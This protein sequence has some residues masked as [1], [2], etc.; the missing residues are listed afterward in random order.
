MY[1]DNSW[2]GHRQILAEYAGVPLSRPVF[3]SIYHGWAAVHGQHEGFRRI[4]GAP[5]FVWNQRDMD[6]AARRQVPNTR[7]IG[8]PFT[9]LAAMRFPQSPAMGKGTIAFPSH[10]AEGVNSTFDVLTFVD[11]VESATPG[12]Y[13]VSIYYRDLDRPETQVYRDAGWKV[14]SFGARTDP[15]FLRRFID[16]VVR[17]EHVVSNMVQTAIWYG[18]YL[19]RRV[20]ILGP[21][22]SNAEG[23]GVGA[24]S[25]QTWPSL[26]SQSLDHDASVAQSAFELGAERMVSPSQLRSE[27]GWDSVVAQAR[28]RAFSAIIGPRSRRFIAERERKRAAGLDVGP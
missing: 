20:Q 16:H 24:H 2:Y 9:Y 21:P 7:C 17:R 28:A 26:F 8:A 27:L 18:A 6:D 10:S 11:A 25:T 23:Q 4:T 22:A 13:T 14:I 5:W 1:P 12:P 3:G 15:E 19:G